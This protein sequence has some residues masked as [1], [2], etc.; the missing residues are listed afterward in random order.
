MIDY[1]PLYFLIFGIMS[2]SL[3]NASYHDIKSRK[4]HVKTWWISIYIALPLSFIPLINQWW[5][6][7]LNIMNPIIAFGLLYPLFIIG[8]LFVMS[9]MSHTHTM[10]GADF[11]AISIILLTN[12][13][14]GLSL[15]ILY[16]GIFIILS[17]LSVII[18]FSLKKWKSYKI[19]LIVTISLAY[20]I[21]IPL[22]FAFSSRF[23]ILTLGLI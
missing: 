9:A 14:M 7:G 18:T 12:I 11:I 17:I 6:G 13:P 1:T 23:D 10:G 3:L 21:A 15:N 4:I 16:L 19:P 5:D 20:L 22:Y 2:L 8:F